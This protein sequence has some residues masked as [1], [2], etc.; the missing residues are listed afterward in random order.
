MPADPST[1]GAADEIIGN[2]LRG[3]DRRDVVLATKVA[4]YSADI[5]WLRKSGVEGTRLD[6]A[7]ICESVE[8]SLKR[9]GTDYIDLLQIGWPDRYSQLHG[10]DTF[11]PE[12]TCPRA[13]F[14]KKGGEGACSTVDRFLSCESTSCT[15]ILRCSVTTTQG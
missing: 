14:E 13:A 1:H 8:A 4:G 9:L 2:W 6:K 10:D 3:R 11:D 5:D 7:N 12:V 15:T